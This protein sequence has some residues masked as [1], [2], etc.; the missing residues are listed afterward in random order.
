MELLGILV[1]TLGLMML[2]SFFFVKNGDRITESKSKI[3]FFKTLDYGSHI[4]P[5]III[6]ILNKSKN[7]KAK[8]YYFY[9]NIILIIIYIILVNIIL[10]W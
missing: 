7:S 10:L 9:S 1:V 6:P 4:K 5:F 3:G 2:I 8:R